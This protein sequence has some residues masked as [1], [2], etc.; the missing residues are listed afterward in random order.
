MSPTLDNF[1]SKALEANRIRF[2][3]LRRLQRDIL[4]Y[5]R[6]AV[7]AQHFGINAA[8]AQQHMDVAPANN[9]EALA[10]FLAGHALLGEFGHLVAALPAELVLTPAIPPDHHRKRHLRTAQVIGDDRPS[11]AQ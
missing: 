10:D 8:M 11:Q 4:P 7:E 1:V 3:D 9:T 5:R 2:G 6:R